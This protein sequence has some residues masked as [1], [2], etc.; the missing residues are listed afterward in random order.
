MACCARNRIA[1]TGRLGLPVLS[2]GARG[3]LQA[4]GSLGTVVEVMAAAVAVINI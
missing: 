3:P 4:V 1:G 2:G